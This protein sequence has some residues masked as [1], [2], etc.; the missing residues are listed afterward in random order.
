[1]FPSSR[2]EILE[3]IL[4]KGKSL[5]VIKDNQSKDYVLKLDEIFI[6]SHSN[7]F[8]CHALAKRIVSLDLEKVK[9]QLNYLVRCG[10]RI[11]AEQAI[12]L[13]S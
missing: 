10:G 12:R 7:G 8:S 9:D 5:K 3:P 11:D 2:S 1:M 6:A 13:V 4:F